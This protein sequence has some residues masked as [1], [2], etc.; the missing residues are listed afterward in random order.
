MVIIIIAITAST[1]L[2]AGLEG[3]KVLAA[4]P[5][6]SRDCAG[7]DTDSVDSSPHND[8]PSILFCPATQIIA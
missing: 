1:L 7:S 6:T 8:L 4:V 3:D 2:I 5:S